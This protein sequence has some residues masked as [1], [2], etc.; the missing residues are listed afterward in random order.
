[1]DFKEI[2]DYVVGRRQELSHLV[3]PKYREKP[4]VDTSDLATGTFV[5]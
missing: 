2:R 1:M 3:D 4:P 5:K